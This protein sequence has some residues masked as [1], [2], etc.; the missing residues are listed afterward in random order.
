MFCVALKLLGAKPEGQSYSSVA[1]THFYMSP[2]QKAGVRTPPD[3]TRKIDIFA[4]GV[5]FF[6]LCY[7]FST[8]MERFKVHLL[9]QQIT[10]HVFQLVATG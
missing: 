5:I 8:D 2:E 7:P 10:E 9:T 1:G 6:E 3:Q 4:L